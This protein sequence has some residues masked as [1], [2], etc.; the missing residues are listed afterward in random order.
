MRRES[1]KDFISEEE[2]IEIKEWFDTC[3]DK[4]LYFKEG[5][6]RGKW[7]YSY[8]LTTRQTSVVTFPKVVYNIFDRILKL[9]NFTESC[10]KEP[11]LQGEGIIA[12]ATL[13]DGDTYAHKDPTPFDDKSVI[14]FNII[15]Q[16]AEEGGELWVKPDTTSKV[17]WTLQE[18]ELHAYNVSDYVHAV[19]KV[20][21]NVPRYI[22]LFSICCPRDD[23]ENH[24]ISVNNFKELS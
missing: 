13:R 17:L 10:V 5:L 18:R 22:L 4:G 1:F 15:I 16:E 9:F 23:W 21:G 8:R 24:I 14:R 7:G 19:S 12:V 20:K 2:R 11:T 3:L 6:S